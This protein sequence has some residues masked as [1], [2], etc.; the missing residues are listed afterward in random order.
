[1]GYGQNSPPSH[2]GGSFRK[3]QYGTAKTIQSVIGLGKRWKAKYPDGPPIGVGDISLQG[4]AAWPDQWHNGHRDGKRVDVRPVRTDGENRPVTYDNDDY[5]FEKTK[6]LIK[7]IFE[8]PNVQ[9][10]IFQ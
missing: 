5:D 6:A 8:D 4:G 1:M 9:A 3:G 7:T 2:G 10:I